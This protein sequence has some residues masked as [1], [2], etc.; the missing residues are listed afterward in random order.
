MRQGIISFVSN[1]LWS[2]SLGIFAREHYLI[3]RSQPCTESLPLGKGVRTI[4]RQAYE[5][6]DLQGT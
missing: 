5:S 6:L 3:E 4:E 1:S 2:K